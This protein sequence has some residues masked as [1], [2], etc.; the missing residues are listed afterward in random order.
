M[1]LWRVGME[2]DFW[3]DKWI[4]KQIGF[5]QDE[6]NPYLF[7]N[8]AHVAEGNKEAVFVPLCGKTKDMIFLKNQGHE[9]VG[10]EFVESAVKEF[11]LENSIDFQ[12]DI[13]KQYIKY[14]SDKITIYVGDLFDMPAS[15]FS[16]CDLFYDRASLIA[17]PRDLRFKYVNKVK[18]LKLKKGLLVTISFDDSELGPPHSVPPV[19]VIDLFE[20]EIKLDLLEQV[21][22]TGEDISVHKD[23]IEN[24][25][26]Y[27]FKVVFNS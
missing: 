23:Q 3:Q 4:N 25:F 21:K 7:R 9:V 11:F 27:A 2:K 12:K 20:G 15:L 16:H 6:F 8:W 1:N 18:E 14:T 17:L 10:V 19:D 24:L 22:E 26:E 5:H 13:Q